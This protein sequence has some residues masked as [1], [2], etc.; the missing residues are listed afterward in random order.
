V[1]E[2]MRGWMPRANDPWMTAT[3]ADATQDNPIRDT[4][5]SCD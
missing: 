3:C 4:V 2:M 5:G 1:S